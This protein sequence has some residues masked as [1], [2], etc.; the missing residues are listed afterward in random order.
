MRKRL[1]RVTAADCWLLD[2]INPMHFLRTV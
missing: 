2:A 1:A